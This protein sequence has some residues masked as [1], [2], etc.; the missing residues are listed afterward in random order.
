MKNT[1]IRAFCRRCKHEAEFRRYTPHHRWHLV[2]TLLTV[3]LWAVSW[4]SVCLGAW[5]RPWRCQRCGWHDPQLQPPGSLRSVR[6]PDG[7]GPDPLTPAL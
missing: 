3:G 2:V 5:F 1:R 6:K 4:L 7:V